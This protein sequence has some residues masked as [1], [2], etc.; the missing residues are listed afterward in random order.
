M[1]EGVSGA[2]GCVDNGDVYNE[3]DRSTTNQAVSYLVGSSMLTLD[4]W[5]RH[6]TNPLRSIFSLLQ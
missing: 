5:F 6:L 3:I 4:S 1:T 2:W